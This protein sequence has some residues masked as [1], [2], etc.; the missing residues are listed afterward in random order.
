MVSA[1]YLQSYF[2][3]HLAAS[4]Y[5]LLS[6]NAKYVFCSAEYCNAET[7]WLNSPADKLSD[8]TKSD[9]CWKHLLAMQ[10]FYCYYM[11]WN[12]LIDPFRSPTT[13]LMMYWCLINLLKKNLWTVCTFWSRWDFFP[14]FLIMHL[15]NQRKEVFFV[16]REFQ[17]KLRTTG[18]HFAK[19]VLHSIRETRNI[20]FVRTSIKIN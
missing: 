3:I 5:L 8:Q 10:L 1:H 14:S 18:K 9:T 13:S 16:S 17:N 20:Q 7:W 11:T 12:D 4:F 6:N 19:G 15:A 2:F